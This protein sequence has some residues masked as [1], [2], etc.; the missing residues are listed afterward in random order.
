MKSYRL[1]LLT[2]FSGKK[3]ILSDTIKSLIKQLDKNDIWIVVLDNQPIEVYDFLQK[4]YKQLKF[5]HHNG[6][7][8]AG[9][10]RNKG[11][12]F[13]INN[14]KGKFLLLP[15]DGDDRLTNKGVKLIKKKMQKSKY[16]IVS[17]GHN[18]IWPDGT[19]R[20]I[21]YCGLFDLQ[22]LLKNYVTPCG[23]TVLKIHNA[24]ILKNFKF[25]SRFRANDVLF[26]LQ[27]VNFFNKFE[28]CSEILLNYRIKNKNSLSAKKY[29]MIFYK[30]MAFKDF[31]L[32]NYT[33]F[34]YVIRYII[35]GLRRH[36]LKHP[37]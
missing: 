26:F 15:F 21:S 25:G 31:G 10:C 19:K 8:G 24:K 2:A 30:F 4:K 14:I 5:L 9:I 7:K 3:K 36:L 17:F 33:S 27:A 34:C 13:I 35:I 6:K 37:I 1:I 28:C 32:K 29:K 12:D 22:A 16:K 18:K 23:S 20:M 11:L